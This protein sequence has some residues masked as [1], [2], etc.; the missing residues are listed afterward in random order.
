LGAK[1][2]KNK[3]A[4]SSF[5]P[6][7]TNAMHITLSIQSIL[8]YAFIG[9]IFLPLPILILSAPMGYLKDWYTR[10]NYIRLIRRHYPNLD[11][12]NVTHL[13][14]IFPH[15]KENE[16]QDIVYSVNGNTTQEAFKFN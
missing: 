5:A 11:L 3:Y 8:T 13:K 12:I 9:L 6:S 16:L 1:S 14:A 2:W 15:K 4:I 7:K 10:Q